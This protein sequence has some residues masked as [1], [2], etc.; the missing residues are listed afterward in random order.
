VLKTRSWSLLT[1]DKRSSPSAAIVAC[2]LLGKG[3]SRDAELGRVNHQDSEE[4]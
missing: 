3:S 4:Q 1:V 2:L